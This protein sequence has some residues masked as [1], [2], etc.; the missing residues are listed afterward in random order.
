MG[1]FQRSWLLMREGMSLLQEN[2]SLLIF[3]I[4]SGI[5]TLIAALSFFLPWFFMPGGGLQQIQAG[6]DSLAHPH[7]TALHYAFLFLFYLVNYFIVI[8]F[9]SALVFCAGKR[10]RGEA[11]TASDGLEFAV[12]NLPRIL[13][14]S[15]MA[16][17]V[18]TILKAIKERVG[19]LGRLVT[20]YVGLA[21][22][23]ATAFVVPVLVF[24]GADPIPAVKRSVELFRRAWGETAIGNAGL[25]LVFGLLIAL[26]VVPIA[27]GF[28]VLPWG[29]LVGFAI[30]ILY[31]LGLAI[32]QSALT[33]VFQTA[34]YNYAANGT[35]TP[36][37]TPELITQ[38]YVPKRGKSS[39]G[40]PT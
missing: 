35:L 25:G 10:L 37:F 12:R 9:N 28:L 33:A 16:A 39:D 32:V 38:A 5:C 24:E 4:C 14:W 1:R 7:F 15:A 34:V 6:G 2:K 36:L 13:V 40:G 29:I 22:T 21:W 11:P 18:G 8:F 26:G 20:I 3:P 19:I 31:W 27:L 30:A 23:L 17:T